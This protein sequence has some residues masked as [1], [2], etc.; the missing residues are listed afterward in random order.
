MPTLQVPRNVGTI[1]SHRAAHVSRDAT[2]KNSPALT[3]VII[4]AVAA[5]LALASCIALI[6]I[7]L[8]KRRLLKQQLE[9]ARLRDPCL[10]LK[11]SSRRRRLTAVDR[12]TEEQREAMI[13]K[14]LASRHSSRSPSMSSSNLPVERIPSLTDKSRASLVHHSIGTEKELEMRLSQ[15]TSDASLGR[16]RSTSTFPEL[17][18]PTLSRSSSLSRPPLYD[19]RPDLPPMLEQHPCLRSERNNT[20]DER[21][22]PEQ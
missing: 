12:V 1:S 10:R 2:A 22:D 21:T 9:E 17:P 6:F 20:V 7:S 16:T 3:W 14:S 19:V 13:R 11:E 15:A 8:S 4:A 18:Q 5:I